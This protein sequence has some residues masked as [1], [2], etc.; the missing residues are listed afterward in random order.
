MKRGNH[1][2]GEPA[3]TGFRAREAGIITIE[4]MLKT[5]QNFRF[6]CYMCGDFISNNI[7]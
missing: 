5:M 1:T 3:T 7:S 4:K 6:C 2:S